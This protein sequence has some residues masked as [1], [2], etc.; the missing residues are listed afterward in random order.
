MYIIFILILVFI[1]FFYIKKRKNVNINNNIIN[2]TSNLA[3]INISTDNNM[4]LYHSNP[5]IRKHYTYISEIKDLYSALT[6]SKNFSSQQADYIIELCK[7]DIAYAN[8]FITISKQY[9]IDIPSNYYSFKILAM[10]Y[11]KRA[12]YEDA[13]NVCQQAIDYGFT[14]DGTKGQMPARLERLQN[15]LNR[16]S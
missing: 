5:I 14:S 1:I 6:K 9:S 16:N 4:Q 10:I 15:K 2:N 7:K 8:Q 12:K 3:T 13:I 11:E